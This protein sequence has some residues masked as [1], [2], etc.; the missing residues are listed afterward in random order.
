MKIAKLI[1]EKKTFW[2][3]NFQNLISA[4]QLIF[5]APVSIMPTCGNPFMPLTYLI[6]VIHLASQIVVLDHIF[7]KVYVFHPCNFW[8]L[9]WRVQVKILDVKC[10]KLCTICTVRLG[11]TNS[12]CMC[13]KLKQVK[14]LD[15]I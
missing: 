7:R 3:E 2:H 8:A 1:I 12:L 6:L 4:H 15:L 5:H 13:W 11:S 14:L 9:Y 10:H